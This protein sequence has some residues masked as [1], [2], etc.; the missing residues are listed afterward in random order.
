MRWYG[1]SAF[2]AFYGFRTRVDNYIE[3]IEVGEDLLSFRNLTAG[4]LRGIEFESFWRPTIGWHLEATGQSIRGEGDDGSG[5]LSDVPADRLRG[6]ARYRQ[7]DWEGEVRWEHRW[8]KKHI[9]GGEKQIRGADLVGLGLRRTL[10]RNWQLSLE[11]E[12]ALDETYFNSADRRVPLAPGR[13]ALL[14]L[15]WTSDVLLN[16]V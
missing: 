14:T 10:S 3:R 7:G 13:R 16:R 8:S 1:R 2:V 4:T 12:N 5:P 11:V 9:G 6:R 15:G